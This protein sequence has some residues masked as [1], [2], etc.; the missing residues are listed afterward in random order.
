MNSLFEFD[1][2]EEDYEQLYYQ[3]EQDRY[4]FGVGIRARVGWDDDRKTNTWTS[5]NP[6]CVVPDPMPS[7][8]GRYSIKNY[9]YMGFQMMSSIFDL[10][11]ETEPNGTPVYR[12]EAL[13]R[14]VCNFFSSE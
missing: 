6:L 12:K 10:M 5:V 11:G 4:F 9:R 13:D 8:T 14:V 3:K 7:Q 2:N 1:N